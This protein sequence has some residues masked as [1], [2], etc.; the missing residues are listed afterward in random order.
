MARSSHTTRRGIATFRAPDD[1][2]RAEGVAGRTWVKN[3][4]LFVSGLPDLIADAADG[5]FGA[6]AKSTWVSIE[7]LKERLKKKKGRP[8]ARSY[9]GYPVL[10]S[11][12]PWGVLLLDSRSENGVTKQSYENARD[13]Y[14]MLARFLG[15]LL[16]GAL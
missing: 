1:A 7:W 3:D 5:A 10:V 2:D 4:A 12:K 16:E 8:L 15:Q 9:G 11:G 14:K 13:Y 6:Y